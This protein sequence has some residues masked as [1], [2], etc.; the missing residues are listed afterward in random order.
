M[1]VGEAQRQYQAALEY[2]RA[3]RDA[4]ADLFSMG[5]EL[6][7]CDEAVEKARAALETAWLRE[8]CR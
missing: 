5:D 6:D 1:N 2:R 7:E 8:T 3:G 4:V